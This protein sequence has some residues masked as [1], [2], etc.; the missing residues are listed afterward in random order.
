M[1]ENTNKVTVEEPDWSIPMFWEDITAIIAKVIEFILS[2][3]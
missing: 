3:F 2:L 1:P